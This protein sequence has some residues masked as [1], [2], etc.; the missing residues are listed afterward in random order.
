MFKATTA[1][2]YQHVVEGTWGEFM[3]PTG[4]VAFL[5]TKARLGGAGTDNER[6]LTSQLRP[7]R[8][9]LNVEQ[10][11]FNQL[12][13]RDLDDHRV[14][15]SL[16]PYLLKPTVNGPSFFPPIMAVLLPFS[17]GK[18]TASFPAQ[19]F[20][21]VVKDDQDI[22]WEDSRFGTAYRIQR[23]TDPQ[24]NHHSIKLGRVSWNPEHA[25]L[26]VLDGQHR[27]MA[28]LAVDRTI[29][30]S[31]ERETGS[32][33][34]HFYEYRVKEL[35]SDH[36]VDLGKVE[37]PVTVCWFPQLTG[38]GKDPHKAARK[39]FV[40]VNKE[41]RAPSEARLTLLSDTELTNIFTRSLLNRLRQKD[42]P[43]PL[44][45]VEY[46]NPER[47]A[48][49][50]IKWSVMTHL[51]LLKT[52]VQ[53]CVFGPPK[54]LRNLGLAFGGRLSAGEM[55]S[56]MR[57]QLEV[58]TLFQDVI[59]DGERVIQRETLGNENFPLQEVDRLTG[60]FMD[61]W[62]TAI[63]TILGQLLP[64]RAHCRALTLTNEFWIAD[65]AFSSLAKDALFGGVGVFWTLRDS[66][67]HWVERCEQAR[68]ED[69]TE[70]PRPDILKAWDIIDIEN[71]KGQFYD[72]NKRRAKEYL[73]K[74]GEGECERSRAFFATVN[75]N[76]C[77]LGA[78][79][80]FA[81]LA[82]SMK[83]SHAEIAALAE[84]VV[85]AWNA[86]LSSKRTNDESRLLVLGR[87]QSGREVIK[88]PINKITKMDTP[89]AVHFRYF[90]LELL[91]LSAARDTLAGVVEPSLVDELA[92]KA[93]PIYTEY[94]VDEQC[95]ALKLS[96]PD[97]RPEKVK[98]KARDNVVKELGKAMAHWLEVSRGDAEEL[99]RASFDKSSAKTEAK[100]DAPEDVTKPAD[101][102]H[103]NGSVVGRES[104]TITDLLDEVP[105]D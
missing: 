92:A 17:S 89:F 59:T 36:S 75:T 93:R 45:A 83:R 34:R 51:N 43:L 63:L 94:L 87:Q 37:I 22:H 6:R 65:D 80:A 19:N 60:R 66:H 50:L 64:Y 96:N 56:F 101:A 55:D 68:R 77:Q 4:T 48:S 20:S 71:K 12:L 27:A 25:Q 105:E 44:Y 35:L 2:T 3:T 54:Y 15:E 28:L 98:A 88:N 97:M 104:P 61:S 84:S 31:W 33:Y 82:Y 58:E 90:W 85:Q 95:K 14:S 74:D 47:N 39:L 79:M 7:V 21:E 30:G 53:R 72:F 52:A 99:V 42:P 103:D 16:I 102:E 100:D 70:P 8:E 11:D 76:A 78:I 29:N 1:V 32:R 24:G 69:R 86:A 41:A 38:P 9:V 23:M 18:P 46:D 10:L 26:V 62:G 40:D 81:T 13:Q 5:L 49:R 67:E 91:R 57:H 73:S